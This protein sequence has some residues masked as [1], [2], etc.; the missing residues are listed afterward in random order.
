MRAESWMKRQA[1]TSSR[2]GEETSSHIYID[3]LKRIAATP[4][5][6]DNN[7]IITVEDLLSSIKKLH[8]ESQSIVE[9]GLTSQI[10][11]VSLTRILSNVDQDRLSLIANVLEPYIDSVKARFDALKEIG[12]LLRTFL[13]IINTFYK[14]KTVSLTIRDGISV[15]TNNNEPLEFNALS[16]GEK[17]LLLL[18]CNVL[19]GTSQPSLFIIDEPEIS[20]NVK[21]QRKLISCLL[22]LVH[23]SQIQFVMATH[24]IELLT[25]HKNSVVEL[26]D[27]IQKV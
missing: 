2:I 18:L 16:S 27:I 6:Q 23:G 22:E 24:S 26:E 15:C 14:R 12:R 21:W 20:L 7:S 8:T 19:V 17:Q 5:K 9:L 25:Q 3:I 4:R 1:L 11:A 13:K 10:S